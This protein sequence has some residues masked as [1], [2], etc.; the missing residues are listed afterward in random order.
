MHTAKQTLLS[1]IKKGDRILVVP[2]GKD[3]F[4]FGRPKDP[5]AHFRSVLSIES[6]RDE[7]TGKVYT[8]KVTGGLSETG[9]Y[10]TSHV[11]VPV[12][13]VEDA[14]ATE[15]KVVIDN[16][17]KVR[18]VKPVVELDLAVTGTKRVHVDSDGTMHVEDWTGGDTTERTPK[19]RLVHIA[20]DGVLTILEDFP[21]DD[22]A[23]AQR[24]A[25]DDEAATADRC[26]QCKGYGVVRKTG[27]KAGKAYRTLV[28]AEEST[29]K[30]N[31]EKCPVCK[32]ATLLVRTA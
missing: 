19:G 5:A 18:V 30:G 32:G 28:G 12:D 22:D 9:R 6:K 23:P 14:P 8:V 16:D 10:G 29:T 15:R 27:S 26:H 4:G 17:G 2:Q 20:A 3:T 11:Y 13:S 21:E 7:W 24:P 1:K 31:S 25:T